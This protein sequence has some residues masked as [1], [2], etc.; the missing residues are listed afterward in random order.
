MPLTPETLPRH[1]LTGLAVTVVDAANAD[2]V[3]ISGHV[4]R[5]TKNTLI[6]CDDDVARQ[7][8]KRDATFRFRLPN[9]TTVDVDGDR[10]V[11]RPAR[12]T[13]TRGASSWV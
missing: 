12:R 4:S 8:P 3:G 2:L 11:A 13:E 1:E 6:V 10:L 5:E 7:V 9:G